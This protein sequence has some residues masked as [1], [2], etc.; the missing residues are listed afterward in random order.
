MACNIVRFYV[1]ENCN[2]LDD[3]TKKFQNAC[4]H[5]IL[6][7]ICLHQFTQRKFCHIDRVQYYRFKNHVQ[8][9]TL[10]NNK[11]V[12]EIKRVFQINEYWK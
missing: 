11:N 2:N 4:G 5:W 10:P 8:S 6:N 9:L 1:G 12:N 3:C 7:S